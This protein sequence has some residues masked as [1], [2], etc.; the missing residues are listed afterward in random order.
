MEWGAK[1]DPNMTFSKGDVMEYISKYR[2]GVPPKV[3]LPSLFLPF[4]LCHNFSPKVS[5]R[6]ATLQKK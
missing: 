3:K 2:S 6:D 1:K 4:S 5:L